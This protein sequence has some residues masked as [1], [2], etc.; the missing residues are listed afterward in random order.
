MSALER[1]EVEGSVF[2]GTLSRSLHYASLRSAPVGMTRS[3]LRNA[4]QHRE[5][6]V[7]HDAVDLVGA[8]GER[9]VPLAE[10]QEPDVLH[11]PGLQ[12]LG[13]LVALFLLPARAQGVAELSG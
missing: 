6:G 1:S 9:L 12:L 7:G 5:A 11:R 3:F 4:P 8:V 13:G 10:R 2:V